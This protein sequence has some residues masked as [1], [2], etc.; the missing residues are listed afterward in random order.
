MKSLA[1]GSGELKSFHPTVSRPPRTQDLASHPKRWGHCRPNEAWSEDPKISLRNPKMVG[2]ILSTPL[3]INMEH[4]HAGLEDDFSFAKR[5]FSGSMLIFWG[6]GVVF[7]LITETLEEG[8]RMVPLERKVLTHFPPDWLLGSMRQGT[9][10]PVKQNICHM[11]THSYHSFK[12][13]FF[14]G[15]NKATKKKTCGKS[16]QNGGTNC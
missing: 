4:N 12:S 5:W 16:S 10:Y 6:V 3:K 1:L 7:V 2:K 13:W 15:R 14:N 8:T 9:H 11:R